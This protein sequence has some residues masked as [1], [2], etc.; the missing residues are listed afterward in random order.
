VRCDVLRRTITKTIT[1]TKKKEEK[2]NTITNT[3]HMARWNRAPGRCGDRRKKRER[4][5]ISEKGE[6]MSVEELLTWAVVSIVLVM[7]IESVRK[8]ED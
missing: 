1:I 6:D 3:S 8:D 2:W 5:A 7:I 4:R